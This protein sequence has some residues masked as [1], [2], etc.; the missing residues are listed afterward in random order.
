VL[1]CFSIAA[2][3]PCCCGCVA[4]VRPPLHCSALLLG[5]SQVPQLCSCRVVQVVTQAVA[6]AVARA[7]ALALAETVASAVTEAVEQ[8]VAGCCAALTVYGAA[9]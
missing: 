8:E 4:A 5:R 2:A 3:L 7:V 6:Q 9:V 1:P